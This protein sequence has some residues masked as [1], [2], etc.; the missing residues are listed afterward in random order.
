MNKFGEAGGYKISALG[1]YFYATA[2]AAFGVIQLIIRNFLSSE[3]QVPAGLPL[4]GVWMVVTSAV[5][6]GAAAM[7]FLRFRRQLALLVVGCMYIL[8]LLGIHFPALVT[9][10]YDGNDWSVTFEGMMIGSGA[11]I[12]AAQLP[13]DSGL[14]PGWLRFI[15]AAATVGHYLFASALFLFAI[16]HIIYFDYIVTLIPAWMPVK[17]GLAYL[18]IAAYILAGISLVL[19]RGVGPA[20]FWLGIM[21][22]LWVIV[23]HAPRAI[24]KWSVET[25]WA[26]LFVALAVC[27]VSFY[28]Y[29]R[30]M[31][32]RPDA[33]IVLPH[34]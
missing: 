9:H 10:I 11:F 16:Q 28:I 1:I 5:F 22:G 19:G 31:V 3:L 23:L 18:V 33:L 26:S 21:F 34:V 7:I 8:F 14:G 29:R 25:E 12:I 2:L 17:V 13:A 27:G 32:S 30:E 24:G 15:Q 4:R 20:A 6:L